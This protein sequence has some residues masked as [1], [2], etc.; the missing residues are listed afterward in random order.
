MGAFEAAGLRAGTAGE[1]VPALAATATARMYGT[2]PFPVLLP[3]G[4]P[5]TVRITTVLD[6]TP[7]VLG[8]DFLVVDREALSPAAARPTTVLMTGTSLDGTAIRK[9]APKAASVHLRSE[10]RRGYV[11]SPSRPARKASTRR[12]W[13]PARD[14]RSWPSSCPSCARPRTVRPSWPA[15]ARWA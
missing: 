8:S 5:L 13:R 9:A 3:D 15:S 10:E 14:T 12:Q 2:R 11:D 6:R 1:A 4:S 7:A